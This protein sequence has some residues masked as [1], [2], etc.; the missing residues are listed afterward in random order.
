MNLQIDSYAVTIQPRNGCQAPLTYG[1]TVKGRQKGKN[2]VALIDRGQCTFVAKAKLAQSAGF[3]AVVILDNQSHTGFTHIFGDDNSVRIPVVFLLKPESDKVRKIMELRRF[4][5]VKIQDSGSISSAVSDVDGELH[6][7][8]VLHEDDAK[9]RAKSGIK[10]DPDDG[11]SKSEDSDSKFSPMMI[12]IFF[13]VTVLAVTAVS[14]LVVYG[15]QCRQ[16]YV[17]RREQRTRCQRA[18]SEI[19]AHYKR[20]RKQ[21]LREKQVERRHFDPHESLEPESISPG[22][23]DV[24]HAKKLL[25]CPVCLEICWPPLKIYQCMQGHILCDS[26]KTHPQLSSCPICRQLLSPKS[27]SRNIALE[28]LAVVVSLAN[29]EENPGG[30]AVPSAPAAED[31]AVALS[32]KLPPLVDEDEDDIIVVE[33]TGEEP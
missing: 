25:E 17:R 12:T 6:P 27:V 1:F 9:S 28:N 22:Q 29:V 13:V 7:L 32:V 20:Q 8:L 3:Q 24:R 26:C 4:A 31:A 11:E 23:V 15:V 19:D 21:M 18:L 16:R 5:R 10:S 30:A 14:T 33:I 2:L